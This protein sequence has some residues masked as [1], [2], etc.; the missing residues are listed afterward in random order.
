MSCDMLMLHLDTE[1]FMT[2]QFFLTQG[3][4]MYSFGHEPLQLHRRLE[5]LIPTAYIFISEVTFKI[6]HTKKI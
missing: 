1:K 5:W 2:K 3:R 6:K 4:K